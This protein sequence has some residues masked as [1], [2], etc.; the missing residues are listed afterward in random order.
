M[1]KLK[2]KD[3]FKV[4]EN[5]DFCTKDN[6]LWKKVGLRMIFNVKQA[7]NSVTYKARLV[8][9]GHTTHVENMDRYASTVKTENFRLLILLIVKWQLSALQGDVSTA[10]LNAMTKE[11]IYANCGPE[12][13][14]Y[15]KALV[16]K[17]VQVVKALYGLKTSGHEWYAE[18]NDTMRSLGYQPAKG[19]SSVWY[20]YNMRTELYDYV[21]YHVDDFIVISDRPDLFEDRL[22]EIYD[23]TGNVLPT[24]HLG[25]DLNVIDDFHWR[26]S[27]NGNRQIGRAHV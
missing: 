22:K 11:T 25:M 10:Y 12:F 7:P 8:A 18:L 6:V 21:A 19:Y 2:D 3:V 13:A 14:A 17:N 1:R 24:F 4:L 20:A 23:I 27:S 26:I 5:K 15:D 16:G 9:G